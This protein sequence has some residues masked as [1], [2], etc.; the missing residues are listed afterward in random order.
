MKK[1]TVEAYREARKKYLASLSPEERK[2][3]ERK[4]L[5]AEAESKKRRDEFFKK[6]KEGLKWLEDGIKANTHHENAI[7]ILKKAIQSAADDPAM[8]PEIKEIA[9]VFIILID[10]RN[11][12]NYEAEDFLHPVIKIGKE[13][14]RIEITRKGGKK[15]AEND[16]RTQVLQKIEDEAIIEAKQFR[17]YG[18]QAEFVRNMLKKYPEIKDDQSILNRLIKLKKENKIASLKKTA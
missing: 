2:E 7:G 14:G 15:R 12:F 3:F 5:E 16:N 9:E 4:K 10:D 13:E 6:N 18:Y 17:R 11:L 1:I 8:T